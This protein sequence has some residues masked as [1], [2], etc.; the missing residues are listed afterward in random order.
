MSKFYLEVVAMLST[1]NLVPWIRRNQMLVIF[2]KH[3]FWTWKPTHFYK[4]ASPSSKLQIRSLYSLPIIHCTAFHQN[5]SNQSVSRFFG[6]ISNKNRNRGSLLIMNGLS[7]NWSI[8]TRPDRCAL[9][10]DE[11]RISHQWLANNHSLTSHDR[12]HNRLS[13]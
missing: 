10:N 8:C 9:L 11:S 5:L 13:D 3:L 12:H 2:Q 4:M 6:N 1:Q 7:N